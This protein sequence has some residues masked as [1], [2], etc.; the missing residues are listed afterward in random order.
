[1]NSSTTTVSLIRHRILTQIALPLLL[2]LCCSSSTFATDVFDF[3]FR[4]VDINSKQP[5]VGVTIHTDDFSKAEIT[6]DRGY[7]FFSGIE[8]RDSLNFSYIGYE[9]KKLTVKQILYANKFIKMSP[10]EV[11]LD[12]IVVVGKIGR[13]DDPIEEIPYQ[14]KEITA[15]QIE[16]K[17]PATSADALEKLG[18]AY[19]QRSQLG[20]GSP[21]IRGFEANRVLLVVDGVRLNNAI[22]RSGH[23]Q[24]AITIDNSVLDQI[25]VITGPGS[26]LYG[27]D[28]LGGVVHFRTKDP[29]LNRSEESQSLKVNSFGRFSSATFE[30]TGHLDFNLGYEKWAFL[31]SATFS[32]FESLRTGAN[33]DENYEGFGYR[34]FFVQIAGVDQVRDNP[35]PL[36]LEDSGYNQ[37]D[38]LQKIRFQ[39][40]DEVYFIGNFQFSTTTDIPRFDKLLDTLD[41]ADSFKYAEWFYGPQKR[42]LGSLKARFLNSNSIYD[43]ATLIA[44]FQDIDEDRN[45][46]RFANIT[47]Q[48]QAEN[49]RIQ[50]Y[51]ADFTKFFDSKEQNM[52]TY[53]GDINFN[54][55]TSRV[56]QIDVDEGL[57]AFNVGDT[58][59]P[60]AGSTMNTSAGYLGYRWRSA[61][62]RLNF[63]GNARYSVVNLSLRYLRTD[64]IQWP[65]DFY[66]GLEFS[67]DALTWG[68]G[69]GYRTKDNWHLKVN[70]AKAF[71]SPNIDDIARIREKNGKL[72]VPNVDLQP[73]ISINQE[74]TLAKSFGELSREN[75]TGNLL[76]LSATGYVTNLTDAIIQVDAPLREGIDQLVYQGELVDTQKRINANSA[77]IRGLSFNMN[78]NFRDRLVI[79]GGVNIT[80]GRS[81]F[82][83]E[84]VQDT[85][86]PF[87]HIPP[88]YGQTSISY[89]GDRFTFEA[90]A[91]FNGTKAIED[92]AVSDIESSG[93]IDR[94]GTSDNLESTPFVLDDEGNI[95]YIG[96]RAWTILNLYSTF[97]LTEKLSINLAVENVFDKFYVPFSSSISAPGRNFIITLRGKI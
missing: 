19:I 55:V 31:S 43:K 35:N 84:F 14:V 67:N 20:G 95:N 22:Y 5:L 59:Y 4:V 6:N 17:N 45:T 15:K 13:T 24:N 9:T 23:L 30:K 11:N 37:V 42:L 49:V 50:S 71:R 70:I 39:P 52:L 90:Q 72:T 88:L 69:G 58:R 86:I 8:Y 65:E 38:I 56:S 29:Q 92:Y 41:R 62:K 83:N 74:I 96:S 48:R 10:E 53:G 3:G 93:F 40:S 73:E 75:K 33:R 61:D 57:V 51:T 80:E 46:R 82:T 7:V 54:T 1:M 34:P 64:A 81:S 89:Q 87:S 18:G 47:R 32:I 66:Q 28:A 26:V 25:E 97:K 12:E 78:Y 91:R 44:A 27:S 2:V 77:T 79:E 94:G 85:I 63:Q 36:I 76:R 16:V 60:S 68:F 21:I